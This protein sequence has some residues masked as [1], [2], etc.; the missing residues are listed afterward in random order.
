[1]KYRDLVFFILSLAFVIF[2]FSPTIYEW[3]RRDT[4]PEIRSFELIH[5]FYTDFNF[6]RSRIRQGLEGA[7]TVKEKYTSET[8]NGSY[9]HIL[10]LAMGWIGRW[11]RVPWGLTGDIYHSARLVFGMALLLTIASFARS[12]FKS[13]WWQL[14][15]FIIAVT[16]SSWPKIAD[17]GDGTWRFGGYMAWWSVMDSHQRITFVPHLV[18]GQAM[19]LW[20]LLQLTNPTIMHRWGNWVFLG[21]IGFILGIIFPP[22][23]LF[24]YGTLGVYV[25]LK[26]FYS[27]DFHF[28]RNF[29]WLKRLI[30]RSIPYILFII[31][32]SAAL[33]YLSLMTSFYPWKRLA[34][35]DITDPLPFQYL[36]YIQAIG[37]V[38]PLGILGLVFALFKREKKM[39]L[40]VSWILAWI[41]FL[42]V[43]NFIPQQSP[44]RFSEMVP[45]VPL[46]VLTIY[47]FVQCTL[48]FHKQVLRVKGMGLKAK[49]LILQSIEY[50]V[51]L[52]FYL[53]PIGLGLLGIAQMHSSYYW[54]TDFIDH[55]IRAG[56]PL[57]PTGSFVMYPLKDFMAAITFLQDATK[58]DT[59]I[60]SETTAGNYIPVYSGNTVYVG[61]ANTVAKGYKEQKVKE[62]YGGNMNNE[63]AYAW[64]KEN[65]FGAVFYGPQEKDDNPYVSDL[66]QLYS[67]LTPAFKNGFVTVFWIK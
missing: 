60:L 8:H 19:M 67:F 40:P 30:Q 50:P 25:V 17:L 31:L 12:Y 51:L 29:G 2:S 14:G 49:G 16:A 9:I 24:L 11:V 38:L 55:K 18:L 33:I 20:I 13:F 3:S 1:M 47:L 48:Y 65:K 56:L 44:L 62:F 35:F 66:T 26:S 46:A 53:V 36:E 43:F 59:V 61:H 42:G 10:Y 27:G 15:A 39:L 32:S 58:R 64:V 22:G 23:I 54:Q 34:E 41:I 57:V 45:H 5:N 28:L 7:L 4:L 6:Y 21:I 52:F 63:E 37:P